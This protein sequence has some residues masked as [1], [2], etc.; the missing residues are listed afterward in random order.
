[1]VAEQINKSFGRLK[2]L[3]QEA[4]LKLQE[5][6]PFSEPPP[7]KPT[8]E[9]EAPAH[10]EE[11]LFQTAM[12]EVKRSQWRHQ[13]AD[14]PLPQHK[15]QATQEA[16]EQEMMKAA[17]AGD[18]ALVVTEHPEYIEGWVGIDGK[19]YITNLRNGL[20]SIQGYLDLHGLTREEARQAVE[21]FIMR[22]SR[23]RSCCVKIIHG[24]GLNSPTDRS[25]LKDCLQQWLATRRMSRRVV[26]YASASLQDGGVGATYVLL[27]SG[28]NPA[29]RKASGG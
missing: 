9:T 16:K 25:I 17:L 24:R 6:P 29:G 5:A 7:A 15:P 11:E 18:P 28:G 1:M 13:V 3:V 2:S 12:G 14:S 23:F 21:E 8:V 4:G 22:M 26:A 27:R 10:S 19:R 20:Y